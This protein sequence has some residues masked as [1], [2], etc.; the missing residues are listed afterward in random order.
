MI[1]DLTNLADQFEGSPLC[2]DTGEADSHVTRE[3][4]DRAIDTLLEIRT[5][6][7]DWDGLGAPAP[8][9][10]VVDTA[11][12]LAGWMQGKDIT[13]PSRVVQSLDG[14]VVFEWQSDGGRTQ[15]DVEVTS[16][17]GGEVTLFKDGRVTLH[18]SF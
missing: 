1:A 10:V 5:L 3:A 16:P 2:R 13:P 12:R 4:W 7:D 14:A 6:K 8:A 17:S 18:Q 15:L 11:I 9:P